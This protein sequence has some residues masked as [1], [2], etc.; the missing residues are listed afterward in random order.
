MYKKLILYIINYYV[1]KYGCDLGKPQGKSI[2]PRTGSNGAKAQRVR[3][4][5][6]QRRESWRT[7]HLKRRCD[8]QPAQADLTG[9]ELVDK[10]PQFHVLP[11]SGLSIG[12]GLPGGSR[13]KN[14]PASAG[15]PETQV[16]PL[17]QKGPYVSCISCIGRQV[18]HH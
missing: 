10:Q 5:G 7:G 17:G 4:A 3:V 6:T 8:L 2:K 14:L 15:P 13:G 9:R 12:Q 18:L 16:R 1:Q 11:L